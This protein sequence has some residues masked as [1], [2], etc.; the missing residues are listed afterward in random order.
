MFNPSKTMIMKE[1]MM[2]FRNDPSVMENR[3]PAQTEQSMQQWQNWISGMAAQGKFGGTGRVLPAG[4]TVAPGSV[5]TDGPYLES[6]EIIGGYLIVKAGT[7]AEAVEAAKGC[8]ILLAGGTVE[9]RTIM[10][11]EQ[12]FET[13]SP[14]HAAKEA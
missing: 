8:P 2:I 14:L 1:Y 11:M 7:L 5:V 12:T 4:P 6:K 13:A 9:V 10:P 3:T